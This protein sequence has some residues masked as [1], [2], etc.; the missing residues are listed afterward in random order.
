M[1]RPSATSS[2][3]S[4]RDGAGAV[5]SSLRPTALPS[6]GRLIVFC[7]SATDGSSMADILVETL[8][9][10]RSFDRGGRIVQ[11]LAPTTCRVRAGDRIALTG[12][13]G[14]GKSTLL[15]LMSG[16]DRPSAGEIH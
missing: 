8:G 13:S 12:P 4:P 2:S 9:V 1:R 6:R 5:R 11:A 10:A 7:I 15:H 3:S 14:S 16:L